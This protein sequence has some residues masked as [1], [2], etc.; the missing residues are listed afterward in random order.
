[1]RAFG[2][3]SGLYFVRIA[4]TP[5]NVDGYAHA[6]YVLWAFRFFLLSALLFNAIIMRQNRYPRA[7]AWTFGAFTVTLFGYLILIWRGPDTDTLRG[8]MIQATC[9]KIIVYAAIASIGA[10][11]WMA[12]RFVSDNDLKLKVGA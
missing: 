10:Q 6:V 7:H 12:R 8:L 4:L 2:V 3:L 11:A 9:Q 1:M 5:A